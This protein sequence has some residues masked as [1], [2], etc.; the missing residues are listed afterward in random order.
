MPLLS[1]ALGAIGATFASVTL[2]PATPGTPEAGNI[3]VTGTVIGSK[4]MAGLSSSASMITAYTSNPAITAMQSSAKN[5][6][7]RGQT[8]ATSGLAYGGYFD[9]TSPDG[10]GAWI[11]NKATTGTARGLFVESASIEGT[12]G[13][14]R[15]TGE[16]IT[17][18]VNGFATSTN[19][20]AAGVVGTAQDGYGVK[21]FADGL[22]GVG[23]QFRGGGTG[24]ISSSLTGNGISGIATTNTKVGIL[25]SAPS[26]GPG[27]AIFAQGTFAATGTKSL[28][29]DHP[30]DPE[31]K[32]LLQFC[33]EGDTP[34]LQY[35]GMVKL[36]SSGSAIVQLPDYFE[37]INRDPI[38]QLTAVGASMPNL[39]V[40][41]KVKN[42][43]FR[44]AGGKSG[45][46]VSWVVIGIRNDKFVQKYGAQTVREK[47]S[48]N[49]GTYLMPELYGQPRQ[50]AQTYSEKFEATELR[51]PVNAPPKK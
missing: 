40:S 48:E 50:K 18:A 11:R 46:E 30:D 36:D 6:A 43:R 20:F 3:N 8:T 26:G 49:Q 9:T 16:N 21:G 38:Y 32:Y 24:L 39:Y 10:Y 45:A 22:P 34:Q 23:G 42:N 44:I 15:A 2:Q 33:A 12:V 7:I 27:H 14:F 51:N 19:D 35:R 4:F 25:A 5:F 37:K 13:D 31:G 41:E 28:M 47:P 1:L 17:L 29:I